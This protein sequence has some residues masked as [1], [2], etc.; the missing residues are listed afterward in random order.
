MGGFMVKHKIVKKSEKIISA[1]FSA[2]EKALKRCWPS[3]PIQQTTVNIHE[4]REAEA[5]LPVIL[6]RIHVRKLSTPAEVFNATL[7]CELPLFSYNAQTWDSDNI[8]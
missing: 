3:Q 6:L 5:E 2:S 4:V 1:F 8:F 7:S